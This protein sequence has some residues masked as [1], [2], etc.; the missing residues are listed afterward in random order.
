MINDLVEQA[1]RAQKIIRNLLEFAREREIDTHLFKIDEI[2][3]ESLQLVSNQLKLH[4]VKVEHQF[5]PNL[6]PVSGDKQQ[7]TQVFLNLALNAI[8]A[9]PNG[10]TLTIETDTIREGSF[11]KINF[12]DSGTGIADHIKPH[13]FDPFFTSKS[14]GKGT[15][16]GLSVSQGIIRKHGGDILVDSRINEGTTFSVLLPMAKIPS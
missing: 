5:T 10:G 16:L 15:G 12:S 2:L 8:D 13:I 7:L 9:M 1:D 11:L 3:E 14:Q 4:K 6:G